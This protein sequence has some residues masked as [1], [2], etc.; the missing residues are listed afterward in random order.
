MF[1]PLRDVLAWL[2]GAVP[3][4]EPQAAASGSGSLVTLPR[5]AAAAAPMDA[6]AAE[7]A[8]QLE[9]EKKLSVMAGLLKQESSKVLDAL[10]ADNQV[11]RQRIS[12]F[13]PRSPIKRAH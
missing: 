4:S 13:V 9:L 1:S 11:C 3:R 7:K 2:C 6:L 12:L 10:R 8:A 5:A